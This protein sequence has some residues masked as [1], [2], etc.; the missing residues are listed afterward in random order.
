MKTLE[1]KSTHIKYKIML[2]IIA[3]G[4]IIIL[5]T[6]FLDIMNVRKQNT[7][8]L[9]LIKAKSFQYYNQMIEDN[10]QIALGTMNYYYDMYKK[11]ILTEKD[12][13]TY[14]I[15]AVKKLRYGKDESGYFWIDDTKGILI[16]HPMISHQ[17]G[18]NRMDDRDPNGVKMV[19]EI[20]QKA[21]DSPKGGFLDFMWEKPEDV[22]T[23]KLTPKRSYSKLFKPWGYIISTGN[24]IDDI[25]A[26]INN[27]EISLKNQLNKN[28]M[29][30]SILSV[31]FIIGL[32]LI[33]IIL[34][35]KIS[36]PIADIT[37]NIGQ[38][39]D[40]NIRINKLEIQSKDEIGYLAEAINDMTGQVR[41]FLYE[42]QDHIEVL[43]NNI[44]KDDD[45]LFNIKEAVDNNSGEISLV[46]EEINLGASSIE[47]I[48]E[49]LYQ[50]QKALSDI[51]QKTEETTAVT[52]EVTER[53]N[54]LRRIS[55]DAKNNT[56][57]VYKEVKESIELS[58]KE[59]ET[60]KEI[61]VL[62]NQINEIAEQ[63]NLISLNAA[64]QAANTEGGN[65]AFAVV[66]DEIKKLAENTKDN[67][68]N[69]Q[70][71]TE[72]IIGTVNNLANSTLKIID[73]VDKDVLPQYNKFTEAADSYSNDAENI[74]CVITDLN[75]TLEEITASSNAILD[76]T[77]IVTNNLIKTANS[78]NS[79]E[80]ENKK[81][82]NEIA[83]IKE[84]SE[85]NLGE[86][87]GLKTFIEK[88][89]I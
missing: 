48:K 42:T 5:V 71:M 13:K 70:D 79:I 36:N 76:K 69:I 49:T 27:E 30:K 64:I 26:S 34:S 68:K 89:D 55:S 32:V 67:I 58:L 22:G 40:G 62:T 43:N 47:D 33:S 25:Y 72:K 87:S 57:M 7:K 12:A 8:E 83:E 3:S 17:E 6:S 78:M 1:Q 66:A 14:A 80:S 56:E 74:N 46:N 86:I 61:K 10:V 45:L 82:V 50:V 85:H 59:I 60:V 4:L 9:E 23:G 77:D 53:A 54:N 73:F 2:S 24:Y 29:T 35:K 84:N 88:F 15:D 21:I 20:I 39:E 38:D 65:K 19:A 31:M 81:V 28:I 18:K 75:A 51:S 41:D 44:K 37:N 63:T 11:G 16:G 52:I